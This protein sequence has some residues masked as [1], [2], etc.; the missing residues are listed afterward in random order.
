MTAL[1][2]IPRLSSKRITLNFSCLLITWILAMQFL[3]A[4]AAVEMPK[5]ATLLRECLRLISQRV[6]K[7]SLISHQDFSGSCILSSRVSTSDFLH[8][9][10]VKFPNRTYKV[11]TP[12][13]ALYQTQLIGDARHPPTLLASSNFNGIGVIGTCLTELPN[14]LTETYAHH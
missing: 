11:S 9:L 2:T 3:L 1:P 7:Y 14:V 6:D 4:A 10:C 5:V 12:L 13:I 8:S